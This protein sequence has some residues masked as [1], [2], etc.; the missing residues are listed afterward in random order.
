MDTNEQGEA[1]V[2][3]AEE[4][5]EEAEETTEETTKETKVEKTKRTP[6]EELEYFEGRASRL[7]KKLGVDESKGDTAKEAQSDKPNELDYGQLALLRTEGIK[8]SAENALFKEVMTETGKGV[9]EVLDSNYFK[10]R[11]ADLR[12]AQASSDA[13]PKGKNRSG[14]TGITDTDLAVAKYKESGNLPDDFKTR[15]A[16]I[17]QI[18]AAEQMEGVFTGPSVIGPQGQTF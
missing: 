11:L 7:R 3:N 15:S 10:S 14:Q 9:L 2:D 6:Q 5:N 1:I 17:K 12:E 16:V 4:T 8:G 18:A 13:I